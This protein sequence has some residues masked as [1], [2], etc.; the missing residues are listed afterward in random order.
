VGTWCRC[1]GCRY[2]CGRSPVGCANPPFRCGGSVVDVDAEAE[3]GFTLTASRPAFSSSDNMYS[4]CI[5]KISLIC[6]G[7]GHRA[8][9]R[10]ASD[11]DMREWE[12]GQR[13]R[14]AHIVHEVLAAKDI[15]EEARGILN[16]R[17]TLGADHLLSVLV[18]DTCRFCE[19]RT[20]TATTQHQ[21]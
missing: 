7:R 18:I 17:A 9:C 8:S 5:S 13:A 10:L 16:I 20:S 21:L 4:V 14:G 3:K 6:K 11:M 2:G 1:G 19:T 15:G 12:E